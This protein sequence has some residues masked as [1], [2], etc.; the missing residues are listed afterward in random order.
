[1][2]IKYPSRRLAVYST[3]GIVASSQPLASAAG[4]EVLA[5]GGN[6]VDAAIA[7]SAALCVTE[8]GST[9]VGGDCFV[10]FY[11]NADKRVHG[12]DG[13]GRCAKELTIQHILDADNG[14]KH[15]HRILESS[16]FS[17]T[18]PGAIAGWLDALEKWG[19]KKVTLEDVLSP[20]IRLARDGFPVGEI[21]SRLWR[22][23]AAKLRSQNLDLKENP[24]LINGEGPE[25]G[26]FVTNERLAR[27]FETV[28]KHGKNGF[29]RGP[30]AEAI[31]K[32]TSSKGHKLNA[33]DLELHESTVVDPISILFENHKVWEIPPSGQGLVALL[34]LGIIQELHDSGKIDLKQLEHNSPEYLHL[35]I[36][37]CKIGFY[38]SDEYVT[39]PKFH[40][41]P[42]DEILDKP[43][44]KK[45]AGLFSSTGIIDAEQMSH[46]VP[47]PKHRSDTIYLTVSDKDGNACSFINSVYNGF[48]SG[49]VVP[50]Y[51]FSLQSRGANFNLNKGRPNSLEG[52]K[53]PYHTIIPSMITKDNGELYA[54]FGNMGGYMQP[55]G[56]VQ[57]V[58][59]MILFGMTPQQLI[60]LPR[61]CLCAHED[62]TSDRGRGS[63]GP[64]ST[65]ITVV[66]LEEGIDEKTGRELEKL[67][68]FVKYV[69]DYERALFGRAQIIKNISKNGKTMHVAGSEMRAD[70]SAIPLV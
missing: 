24:L 66:A 42:L 65:P 27:L 48:G 52:G 33:Q 13:C 6:C 8:P 39:D 2:F 64:V 9:G 50:E 11:D 21:A 60:D 46:G 26:D 17:V 47:D 67:G 18:V 62:T 12:L 35:L 69:H 14:G 23:C 10:L 37:A 3:N 63:D 22:K 41:I 43:Y 70:G 36:E 32:R 20:S 5:K 51:G 57:H 31:V 16:I 49:I 45:R 56:H 61:F 38:D 34:A 29:Y 7:A 19:S 15:T 4:I 28:V 30:V 59:N 40:H 54:S 68:H 55:V 58:L 1:M 25:E 53:R 44:L